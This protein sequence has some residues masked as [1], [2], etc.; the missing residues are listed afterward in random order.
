MMLI[1]DTN[2]TQKLAYTNMTDLFQSIFWLQINVLKF[3]Q[4]V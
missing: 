2:I 1:N 4:L 3:M